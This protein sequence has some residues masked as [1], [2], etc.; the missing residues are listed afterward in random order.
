[1]ARRRRGWGRDE[2]VARAP[3]VWADAQRHPAAHQTGRPQAD[4]HPSR[5]CRLGENRPERSCR[6]DLTPRQTG[7]CRD[8]VPT[9]WATISRAPARRHDRLG[10]GRARSAGSA[11]RI[12]A[13]KSPPGSIAETAVAALEGESL[14]PS[15][16]ARAQNSLDS[17]TRP[18]EYP[19]ST[20]VSIYLIGTSAPDLDQKQQ[21]SGGGAVLNRGRPQ[22]TSRTYRFSSDIVFTYAL[23]SLS[24]I[25]PCRAITS[26][27]VRFTSAAIREASPQ[28]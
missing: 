21:S 5:P 10:H 27:S 28:T 6:R 16:R 19:P 4:P 14:Q 9:L 18:I 12:P 11:P 17:R 23:A 20:D 8:R 15:Q 13:E 25:S 26:I 3:P 1:M 22:Y 2:S 24:D 7:Q